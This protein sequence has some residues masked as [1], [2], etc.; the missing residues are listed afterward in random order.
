ME[1]IKLKDCLRKWEPPSSVAAMLESYVIVNNL[2]RQC[3]FTCIDYEYACSILSFF[4]NKDQVKS[5]VFI[6]FRL[7]YSAKNSFLSLLNKDK[8]FEKADEF[9][10]EMYFDQ[11]FNKSFKKQDNNARHLGSFV[12]SCGKFNRNK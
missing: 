8:Q 6:L 2:T 3:L 10:T 9:Y 11:I 12:A 4:T 7:Q 1:N 5:S